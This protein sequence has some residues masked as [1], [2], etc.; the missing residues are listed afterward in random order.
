MTAKQKK[1]IKIIKLRIQSEYNRN[2]IVNALA[3]SGYK[4]WIEKEK[5]F[6]WEGGCKYFVL[7]E[8]TKH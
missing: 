8:L 1:E 5:H 7:F 6:S 4:V 3:D 2:A